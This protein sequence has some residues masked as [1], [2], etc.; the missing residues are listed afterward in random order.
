MRA[1]TP[2]RPVGAPSLPLNAPVEVEFLFQV[3]N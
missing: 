1:D 3:R 2:A